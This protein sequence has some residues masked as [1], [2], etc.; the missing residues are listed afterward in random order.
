MKN[1][2]KKFTRTYLSLGLFMMVA[3][4]ALAATL[5]PPS[6]PGRPEPYDITSNDCMVRYAKPK[7]DGGTR[8]VFYEVEKKDEYGKWTPAGATTK[9]THNVT[10]LVENEKYSFRVIAH[11]KAGKS[12]PSVASD[13]ITARNPF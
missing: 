8:I 11:N 10:G 9:L 1:T 5:D 4:V 13:P 2:K 3:V 7:D 6:P 12:E